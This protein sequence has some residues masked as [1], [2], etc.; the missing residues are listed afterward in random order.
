MQP[1]QAEFLLRN[2][3]PQIEQE[4]GITKK[5]LAAVPETNPGYRPD[6]KARTAL[7]LAQH[8]VSSEVWFLEG[9]IS[10]KFKTEEGEQPGE[11]ETIA[12][13]ISW[14]ERTAPGLVASLRAMPGDRLAAPIDF[15]GMLHLPAVNYLT[16]LVSHTIHHRGQLSTYLR[17]MGGKVPSIYGGSADE[18]FE[19]AE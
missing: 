16:L 1:E 18:P 14:Y 4:W 11:I 6:P 19:M 13:A 2:I 5:V 9:I 12:D 3:L 17:P 7:E 8:I 15:M 10:G